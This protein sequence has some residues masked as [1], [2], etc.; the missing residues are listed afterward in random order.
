MTFLISDHNNLPF[1]S[2]SIETLLGHPY[3]LKQRRFLFSSSNKRPSA[4]LHEGT[5]KEHIDCNKTKL[6]TGN[7]L[8][9]AIK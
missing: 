7:T 6:K 4:T 1:L 5:I 9:K 2:L 3:K 8:M